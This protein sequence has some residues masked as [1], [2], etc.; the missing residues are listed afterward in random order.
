MGQIEIM[1]IYDKK[2]LWLITANALQSFSLWFID[3]LSKF[4]IFKSVPFNIDV[5]AKI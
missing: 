2:D 5:H 4:V 3:S 1:Q